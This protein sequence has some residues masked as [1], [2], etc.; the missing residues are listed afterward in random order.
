[1]SA[2][3]VAFTRSKIPRDV[4]TP[5]SPMGPGC[6]GRALIDDARSGTRGSG[7]S[8]ARSAG[9]GDGGSRG[10]GGS[11]GGGG[12]G[13]I[14]GPAG[15]MGGGGGGADARAGATVGGTSSSLWRLRPIAKRMIRNAATNRGS[16]RNGHTFVPRDPAALVSTVKSTRV[17]RWFPAPSMQVTVAECAPSDTPANVVIGDSVAGIDTGVPPSRATRH[18]VSPEPASYVDHRTRTEL[19]WT[20]AFCVGSLIVVSGGRESILIVKECIASTFPAMSV[21]RKS[22]VCGP[23]GTTGN[24]PV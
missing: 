8:R 15:S 24:A 20:E 3:G 12:G 5:P 7:R 19:E 6:P 22:I 14:T 21:A 9:Y 23:S 13:A 2:N 10:A 16:R 1:M 11:S 4:S 18:D 17:G